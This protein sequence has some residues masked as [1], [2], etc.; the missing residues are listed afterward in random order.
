MLEPP[1]RLLPCTWSASTSAQVLLRVELPNCFLLSNIFRDLG[2]DAHMRT[3]C[4]YPFQNTKSLTFWSVSM[5][6]IGCRAAER[7]FTPWSPCFGCVSDR[8]QQGAQHEA[9]TDR[10]HPQRRQQ[11]T[12]ASSI[13]CR[14]SSLSSFRCPSRSS[15]GSRARHL[16]L[17]SRVRA[18]APFLHSIALD[19]TAVAIPK[20]VDEL[21]SSRA[22]LIISSGGTH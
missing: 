12:G 16:L 19:M 20:H 1:W 3:S 18:R 5:D 17:F 11:P 22:L 4:C 21:L 2:Q 9:T 7:R 10:G 8:T 15:L 6:T 13:D 14:A